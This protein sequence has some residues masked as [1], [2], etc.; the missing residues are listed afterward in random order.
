MRRPADIV[1]GVDETPPVSVSVLTGVQHVAV[2]SVYLVFPVLLARAAGDSP[3]TAAAMVSMTLVALA[4]ATLL[5]STRIGSGFLCQPIPSVLY[6]IPSI[7]AVKHG[8]LGLA[9]GMTVGAGLL[10]AVAAGVFRRLRALF[11]PE[12][13]GLVVLLAGIATGMAGLRAALG[14]DAAGGTRGGTELG[15]ALATL[16][17]MVALNVWGRGP[18]RLFCVLIGM[19]AGYGGAALLGLIGASDWQ[20]VAAAPVVALPGI[21][22]V[23]WSFEAAFIVPFVIAATAAT[24][25]TMGNVTTSQK[26][27]D[28]EWARADLRSVARGI[29]ADGLGSALAGVL[30]A[31][32]L[33][34]STS[35]VG[36]AGA[37][38]VSS[39]RVA[40]FIAAMLLALAF[41]PKLGLVFSLMPPPVSGATLVFASTFI[42]VNGLE[43]IASR[44]LDARRTLV[45]GLAVVFGLAVEMYPGLLRVLPDGAALALGTSI[46]FGTLVGLVLNGLF[47]IGVRR[48]V[49]LTLPGGTFDPQALEQW[50]ERQGH[51]WGARRDVSERAKFNLLQSIET[52]VTSGLADGPIEIEAAFDEFRLDLRVSYDGEALDLPAERPSDEEILASAEGERRLAGY[53]LRRLADRVSATRRGQRTTVLFHF[54]H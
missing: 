43:I 1:Y 7:T 2:M 11:P 50:M 49:A 41:V 20:K 6:F 38:G 33:N 24:L 45:I 30:G 28:A 31:H 17:L 37:T 16:A 5:Q 44:L 42:V 53:V 48:R 12:I 14:P 40:W 47:R 18:L 32:G 46:V 34:S 25:K 21:A 22:H 9:F 54:D 52:L 26:I 13:A 36:L 29:R 35:A 51:A 27:N 10:E 15:L 4:A 8:G 3:D 19:V 39:R 23:G